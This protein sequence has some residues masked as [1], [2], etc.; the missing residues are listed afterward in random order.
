MSVTARSLSNYQVE[1]SA[2]RH[3]LIS[4]EPPP[5]G[6]DAGPNPFDLLLGGL[7][8]CVVI[9]L[10]MYARRKQWPLEGVEIELE[11]YTL[12]AAE[13]P[14]CK[15]EPGKLVTIIEKRLTFQGAL[16][17]EQIQRLREIADKCP[18]HKTLIGEIQIRTSLAVPGNG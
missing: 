12:P 16:S 8:S 3:R 9:T 2:G 18:V 10:Q 15:S 13:C 7:G 11:S 4:D 14:G 17:P 5:Q 6:D 1:I